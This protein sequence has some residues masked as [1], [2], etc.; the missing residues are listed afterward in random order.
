M[1]ISI[2]MRFPRF[3]PLLFWLGAGGFMQ[4][5]HLVKVEPSADGKNA[6]IQVF[7]AKEN[8]RGILELLDGKSGSCVK[9]LYAGTFASG[10]TF[11]L[12]KNPGLK[13]G[14][15]RVR[16][17]DGIG[18]ATNLDITLQKKERWNNPKDIAIC[19][20]GVYVMDPGIPAKPPEKKED[21]TMTDEVPGI[22][23]FYVYKFSRDG[24]PDATFGDRGRATIFDKP[25]AID[26]MAVDSEG[27]IYIPSGGHDSMVVGPSGEPMNQRIGGYDGDPMGPKCTTWLDNVAIGP[28]KKIYLLTAAAYGTL[29]AYDRLKNAFDGVLYS[30]VIT[31]VGALPRA[32]ASDQ[33]G[34][35]YYLTPDHAFQKVEDDGKALKETYSSSSAEKMYLPRGPSA[36]GGLIW[37]VDHGPA[38]PFWDSGGD[39]DL[40]L[41][42]DTGGD[43]VFFDR[44]GGPGKAA[45]KV[46]FLNPSAVAQSPD[47]LELWV[48]EDGL[49][50]V[51]GPPGNKRVRKF[52]ITAE[53]TEEVPLELK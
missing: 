8:T 11:T 4:A 48:T 1:H 46:E 26:S 7:P 50:N 28:G 21:G 12:G 43:I 27:L 32:V 23:E 18:V 5:Q 6:R 9:T 41:F 31:R 16:Y 36:S 39:N 49:P 34:S 51:D 13:A 17:R 42:W 19:D 53:N 29:R 47:H 15:W 3:L 44:F 24:K 14:S 45:D 35:I 52:S 38:G 20:K 40:L 30:M 25:Y 22:G 2:V 37:V 33:Q 10:Q